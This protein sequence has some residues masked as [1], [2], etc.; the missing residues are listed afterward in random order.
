MICLGGAM[1]LKDY[2]TFFFRITQYIGDTHNE[3][4]L[5]PMNT[6]TQTLPLGASLPANHQ[7]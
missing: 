2:D 7:D 5:V 6:H 4:T 3:C 1:S